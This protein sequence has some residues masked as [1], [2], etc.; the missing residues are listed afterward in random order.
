MLERTERVR[1][2]LEASGNYSLDLALAL[3]GHGQ[4]EVSVINPRRARKFAES[5]GERSKTDPVDARVL[6]CSTHALGTLAAPEF[7]RNRLLKVLEG[8]NIKLSSVATDV[9]G[10]SGRLMLRA[11][12][13]G[14]TSPQEMATLAK[15]K[16]RKKIQALEPALEGKLESHHRFLLGLQLKRVQAAEEDL[17]TLEQQIQKRLE[18]YAAQLALLDEIP[19]VNRGLAAAMIAELGGDMK[20]F[21]RVSQLTS[22]AGVCPGNNESAANARAAVSPKAMFI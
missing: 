22:W 19:G 21:E 9:F 6:S 11:L 17:A 20:V 15:G 13:D 14:K 8:A 16:F 3:H 4:V 2:C 12:I 7:T 10:V 18:P 5:L 1:V